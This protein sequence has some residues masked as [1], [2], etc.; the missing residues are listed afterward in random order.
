[1][2]A[3][4]NI[5]KNNEKVMLWLFREDLTMTW[6]AKELEQTIQAVSNKIKTNGFTNKDLAAIKRLGCPL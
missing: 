4:I 3:V 6:L 2:T 1:M 5:I